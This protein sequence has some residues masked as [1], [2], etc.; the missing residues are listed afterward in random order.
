MNRPLYK[1]I[2]IDHQRYSADP[3]NIHRV[4]HDGCVLYDKDDVTKVGFLETIINFVDNNELSLV[5]RPVILHSTSDTLSIN[6][7]VYRCTNILYGTPH[8]SSIEVI[9]YKSLIQK[10]AFR[11]GTNSN[12]PPLVK[13]M[14][15][16][17][18]PNLHSST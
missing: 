1:S 8:G 3:I 5:M 12:F 17:Q 6:D 10:L 16:F 13:S 15:F 7:R 2:F 4:T 14:F 9:H 18:F 11:Y